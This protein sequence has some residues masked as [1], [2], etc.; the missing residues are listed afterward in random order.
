MPISTSSSS[1]STIEFTV[2]A[3]QKG[4]LKKLTANVTGVMVGKTG[5]GTAT[6]KGA[7]IV[8]VT[9]R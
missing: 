8:S 9:V 4:K 6:V 2:Y 7:G 5:L 1:P 3:V